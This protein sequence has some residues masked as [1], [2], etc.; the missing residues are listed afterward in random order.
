[1]LTTDAEM[2]DAAAAKALESSDAFAVLR[3]VGGR[4]GLLPGDV[5]VAVDEAR[6]RL[7]VEMG[8][9]GQSVAGHVATAL[10]GVS[11]ATEAAVDAKTSAK[12]VFGKASE[13][14]LNR[15]D[16]LYSKAGATGKLL[17]AKKQL[18]VA[19]GKV[20]DLP[21][22]VQGSV[23]AALGG[24]SELLDGAMSRVAAARTALDEV[25]TKGDLTTA[26]IATAIDVA[27][28]SMSE[29]IV[30]AG[31]AADPRAGITLRPGG[32]MSDMFS[33]GSAFPVELPRQR[34]PS[35]STAYSSRPT[36]EPRPGRAPTTITAR[37][38]SAATASAIVRM[39][40]VAIRACASQVSS[41]GRQGAAQRA[42]DALV[43]RVA[44]HRARGSACLRDGRAGV[45]GP[46]HVRS[47][48]AHAAGVF[49]RRAGAPGALR[50]VGR[51]VTDRPRGHDRSSGRAT[52]NS[53]LPPKRDETVSSPSCTAPRDNHGLPDAR[54][55]RGRFPVSRSRSP[56]RAPRS[57][58][59]LRSRRRP[60]ACSSSDS[61]NTA[62]KRCEG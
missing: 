45:P 26:A 19:Q 30:D 38:V 49:A 28:T 44:R 58:L 57:C 53:V 17:D 21:A 51:E 13:E 50:R 9:A 12:E 20:S 10:E 59:A 55:P 34:P 16:D 42:R 15:L 60:R 7:A 23:K 1:M 6:Q 52:G 40:A 3:A 43:A 54:P 33:S 25:S 14:I 27:S 29:V 62:S 39:S 31:L 18:V 8:A 32:V 47:P 37:A 35:G 4:A 48:Y 46:R 11:Q 24:G 61:P 56:S 36:P 41:N 22:G 2:R 5:I